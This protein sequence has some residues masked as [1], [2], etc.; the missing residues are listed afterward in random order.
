MRGN[1]I[2]SVQ[3]RIPFVAL[4]LALLLAVTGCGSSGSSGVVV[5]PVVLSYVPAAGGGAL[6]VTT[7]SG[8]ATND[9]AVVEINA[10]DVTDVLTASFVLQFDPATVSYL[11]FDIGSSHLSSD[12]ATLQPIVQETT[13]GQLTVGLTR[14]SATGIDFTGTRLV[15]SV[16]FNRMSSSGMS[17]LSFANASLLDDSAPPAPIPGLQWF[18]GTFQIN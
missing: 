2:L 18:G 17:T 6:T 13:P 5:P 7:T 9:T 14:L 10:T 15:L 1:S 3:H 8:T 4:V 12:G 16:R 11:D